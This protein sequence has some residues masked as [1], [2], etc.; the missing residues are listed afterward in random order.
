MRAIRWK[1]TPAGMDTFSDALQDLVTRTAWAIPGTS[2]GCRGAPA[3]L[4]ATR[5]ARAAFEEFGE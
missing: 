1:A 4:E 3:A 2:R 5:V